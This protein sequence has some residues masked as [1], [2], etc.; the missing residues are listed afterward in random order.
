MILEG[1]LFEKW[2][3]FC[4]T[5]EAYLANYFCH[6]ISDFACCSIKKHNL[7]KLTPFGSRCHQSNFMSILTV[8]TDSGGDGWV[9]GSVMDR[10]F[11]VKVPFFFLRGIVRW[12]LIHLNPKIVFF[13]CPRSGKKGKKHKLVFISQESW[14]VIHS[15]FWRIPFFFNKSWL[16]FFFLSN[17]W[18]FLCVFFPEKFTCHSF[19]QF[20]MRKKN[21][22]GKKHLFH[23]FILY[24]S[25]MHR[26]ELIRWNKK[27]GPLFEESKNPVFFRKYLEN[28]QKKTKLF[29]VP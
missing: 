1:C 13:F 28:T 8:L 10:L 2:R 26:N 15:E 5:N 4:L 16:C 14:S 7:Q 19:I 25:K 29:R 11:W 18:V 23:S 21:I 17:F 6:Q 3:F 20:L 27:Y 9:G 12:S 24:S 22:T